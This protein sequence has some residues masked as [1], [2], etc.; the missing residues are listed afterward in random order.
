MKLVIKEYI[1]TLKE[2]GELDELI[3]DLLLNM[4]IT[5][6]SKA[7]IGVR[8]YGVD[9]SAIGVDPEDGKKKLFLITAKEGDIT[10]KDWDGGSVQD[11]RPSLDEIKDVAIPLLTDPNHQKLPKKIIVTTN[12]EMHQN[13]ENN[14]KGYKK[15]NTTNNIEYEFWGIDKL[16]LLI[17]E[18]FLNE[19]LFP[20]DSQNLFRK[21]L[22]LLDDSNYDLRDYFR[23]VD[24]I[25]NSSNMPVSKGTK[26]D[27]ERRKRI[28]LLNLSI[29]IIHSWGLSENNIL[30]VYKCGEGLILKLYSW[31]LENDLLKRKGTV[32]EFSK[33]LSTYN[34]ISGDLVEKISPNF[35]VKGGLFQS[36]QTK[37]DY[38]IICFEV[39]GII[40]TVGLLNLNLAHFFK[41]ESYRLGAVELA[42]EMIKL[43]NTNPG[44]LNPVYD[45]HAI[46]IGL[47]LLLFHQ[48][49]MNESVSIWI[50]N[51]LERLKFSISVKQ[52]Y[53]ISSDSY[54]DL[55]EREYSE[56]VDHD[57]FLYL[58]TLIPMLLFWMVINEEEQFYTN[59]IS[60]WNKAF[61]D[62]ELQLWLPEENSENF[63]LKGNIQSE[64]GTALVSIIFPED[65][66]DL[67][68]LADDISKF[69]IEPNKFQ[70]IEIGLPSFIF[71]SSRHYR[72]PICPFF[73]LSLID[74][75]KIERVCKG[76][77]QDGNRCSRVIK[78]GHYC[79]QHKS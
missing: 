6:L 23:F 61:S 67:G 25:L 9:I 18:Y 63:L 11:V 35:E 75:Q 53:P 37:F 4:G 44:C 13:V 43:I 72:N 54:F 12:G 73:Y 76:M 2:S 31:L 28:R 14:W 68:V 29:N 74:L 10:R 39:L 55:V 45:E 65:F 8:Q 16:T 57:R 62:L 5:P 38:P 47:G 56:E 27:K 46:D 41:D 71:M 32:G 69:S 49:N 21:T 48:L 60:E 40:A 70:S 15:S 7:Q 36:D 64:T 17:D 20:E 22:A 79:Y 24:K 26:G 50:E 3:P 34:E 59:Q 51:L 77:K 19:Y 42:H 33:L 58:S 30:S 78:S 1:S 66:N 52:F